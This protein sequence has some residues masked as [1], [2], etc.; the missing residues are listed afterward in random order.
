[1]PNV[2]HEGAQVLPHVHD[3]FEHVLADIHRG[4]GYFHSQS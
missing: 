3:F 4:S 2:A 1:V